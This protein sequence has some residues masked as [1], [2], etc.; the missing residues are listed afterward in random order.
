[1]AKYNKCV[2]CGNTYEYC[3]NCDK[4]KKYWKTTFC[5]ESCKKLYDLV[6]SFYAGVIT[7]EKAKE[8]FKTF[9]IE[10]I[11]KYNK[12]IQQF[13]F[14]INYEEAKEN[15]KTKAEV[16]VEEKKAETNTNNENAN[17]ETKPM[18]KFD[19]NKKFSKKK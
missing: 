4:S 16:N 6:S 3:Q 5:C 7:K 2:V 8:E 17:T 1:M 10:D 19:Y 13:V 15:V 18:K 9:T 11:N 14:D 12:S